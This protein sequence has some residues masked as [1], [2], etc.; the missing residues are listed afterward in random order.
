VGVHENGETGGL[1]NGARRAERVGFL[2]R[3]FFPPYELRGLGST[4]SS[5]SG[6]RTLSVRGFAPAT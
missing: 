5:R 6:V 3:R 4:V 2:G 1:K